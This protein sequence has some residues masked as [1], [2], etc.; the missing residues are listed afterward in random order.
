MSKGDTQN[1]PTHRPV[2]KETVN[3][4]K[5]SVFIFNCPNC[6]G[7]VF[8]AEGEENC[9]IFR[10]GVYKKGPLLGL[11]INP[12]ETKENIE[13]LVDSDLI[14]GCGKP[15]MMTEDKMQV[16]TCNFI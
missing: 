13:K 4:M 14:Y 9:H 1:I 3:D 7:T 10:H 6:D 2:R 16:K 11:P 12:H 5:K 15:I 8:V